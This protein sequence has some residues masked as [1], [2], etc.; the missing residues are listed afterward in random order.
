[1]LGSIL[2]D[3]CGYKNEAIILAIT[4]KGSNHNTSHLAV[5]FCGI[6]IVSRNRGFTGDQ[7]EQERQKNER[8]HGRW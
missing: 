1:M 7:R 4:N 8:S 5:V 2:E 6:V 3:H